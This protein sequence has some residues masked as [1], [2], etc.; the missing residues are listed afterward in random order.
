MITC[1]ITYRNMRITKY[2]HTY[3]LYIHPHAQTLYHKR[4]VISNSYS[5]WASAG[6]IGRDSIWVSY[7]VHES[8]GMIGSGDVT[9]LLWLVTSR[10]SS[11][12]EEY[13][14][15]IKP[16]KLRDHGDDPLRRPQS[17]TVT[18]L[19]LGYE[20]TYFHCGT[21]RKREADAIN[22][23]S[24]VAYILSHFAHGRQQNGE[25]A[26]QREQECSQFRDCKRL[27]GNS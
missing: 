4:Y 19:L 18:L 2:T 26:K 16:P 5:V 22:C 23:N 15:S 14:L 17:G 13:V 11:Y 20:F 25:S 10:D 6:M 1:V 12:K 7:S 24:Y 9:L 27:F 3:I 8:A 21:T